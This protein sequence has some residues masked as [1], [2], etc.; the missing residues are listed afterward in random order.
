MFTEGRETSI[1]VAYGL[2]TVALAYAFYTH[3]KLKKLGKINPFIR[4]GEQKVSDSF[5]TE[6]LGDRISL[7]RCWRSA[8]F[9]LCDG[10]HK[11]YNREFN[12]NTGPVVI[13]RKMHP[14]DQENR[15]NQLTNKKKK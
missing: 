6:E 9:P 4:K 2:T 12:D 1:Y 3:Y 11:H 10:A 14:K 13:K 7:C 5:I 8:T 15:N